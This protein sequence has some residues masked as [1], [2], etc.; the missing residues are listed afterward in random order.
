MS[1]N[2]PDPRRRLSTP[3]V[4]AEELADWRLLAG[5]LHAR[6][7]PADY[8]TGL[9][10]VARIGAA[11]E[12]AD[13]HPETTLTYGDVL[14]T[15]S[16]HDVGG[17]TSRDVRLARRVSALA[18]ELGIRADPGGLSR[19]EIG[20]DTARGEEHAR[21]YAA[22]LGA[23]VMHEGE[24]ADPSLQAPT[25]WWQGPAAEGSAGEAPLPGPE[26]EQRWHFDVW[27]APEEA[28]AR[29]RAGL[30]AGGRL[31]SDAAA[32]SFWVVEDVDGNR[33]CIC[34]SQDRA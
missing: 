32:P 23:R 29:L 34:T 31:V 26:V 7:V 30:D 6:F 8:A 5:R 17:V 1:E 16:S 28:E 13:H 24:V 4:A 21:F 14:L 20:L 9:E 18:E 25:L 19:V 33:S 27:V 11:A 12:A 10:F 15:L 22:L 2:A 3:E